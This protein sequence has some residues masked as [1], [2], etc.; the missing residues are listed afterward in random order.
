[1]DAC[2]HGLYDVPRAKTIF[3][4][5]REK[6][7]NPALEIK[8]YNAFLEA[9]IDMAGSHEKDRVYWIENAWELYDIL[10]SGRE[11]HEPNAST[12]AIMLIAW[13]R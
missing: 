13:H 1:M 3:E 5:M 12:Y 4:R 10:E 8:V 9:Y 2:L 7:G 6:I 11:K